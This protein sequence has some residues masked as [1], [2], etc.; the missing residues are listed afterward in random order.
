MPVGCRARTDG[1]STASG[2][3]AGIALRHE[4]NDFLL[5]VGG[6][7][8][9]GIRPSA[10]RRGLATWA[11]GRMLGEARALG[12]DRV[13][14]TCEVDNIASAKTMTTTAVSS[15][16]SGTPSSAPH[17]GAGSSS[18]DRSVLATIS[19]GSSAV[20][21]RRLRPS[22]YQGIRPHSRHGCA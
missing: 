11:L 20:A 8:G 12:L 21:R 2:C 22:S 13:L 1:S 14:I 4:L 18:S 15:R 19:A 10:R 5:R 9:Y 17:G 6:H 7:V 3:W 16:T